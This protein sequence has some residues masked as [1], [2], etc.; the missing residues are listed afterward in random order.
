[1]RIPAGNAE[2]QIE[3]KRSRFI[4]AARRAASRGEVKEAVARR[5][6]QDPEASHIVWAFRAGERGDIFGMSDDGEPQG[7]AGRPVLEVIRGSGI[8]D[9]LV[10]VIRYFGGTKLGTGGLVKA[11]TE[12]AKAVIAGLPTEERV[13]RL[14]FS[15]RLP[16]GAYRRG[17]EVLELA[18]AQIA[19]ERFTESVLLSGTLPTEERERVERR[20]T[21]LTAGLSRL[22]ITGE[23]RYGTD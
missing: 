5:W 3:I 13:P 23:E 16:Y 14:P 1:M 11:Y 7:T 6:E 22:E 12:A 18:G 19:D 21:D 8:S 9:L 15:L 17:R 20:I 10:M 4:A 2:A